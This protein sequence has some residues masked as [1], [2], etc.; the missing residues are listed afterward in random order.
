AST[1]TPTSS[2]KARTRS[3][4]SRQRSST[5]AV[6]RPSATTSP[7][8]LRPSAKTRRRACRSRRPTTKSRLISNE[9]RP[10]RVHLEGAFLLLCV[11]FDR[12]F[13]VDQEGRHLEG[14]LVIRCA[15]LGGLHRPQ[16]YLV[17]PRVQTNARPQRQRRNLLQ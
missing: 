7:T 11:L 2:S 14:Q 6:C 12:A 13:Q 3:K 4:S 8:S 15:N 5:S 17:S 10:L 9:T 16:A 1:P